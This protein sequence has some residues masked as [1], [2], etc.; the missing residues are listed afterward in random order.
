MPRLSAA[1]AALPLRRRLGSSA[2][3]AL[4]VFGL[5][6]AASAQDDAELEALERE[7]AEMQ[8]A[9][10]ESGDAAADAALED[11]EKQ[12]ED[13]ELPEGGAFDE[14]SWTAEDSDDEPGL[15]ESW[16][17]DPTLD[18]RFSLS[19][20][21]SYTGRYHDFDGFDFPFPDN[22]SADDLA[23]AR[24]LERRHRDDQDHDLDQHLAFTWE[25]FLE[26][27]EESWWSS[28]D[29]DASM[30]YFRDL[31]GSSSGEATLGTFDTFSDNDEFQ[32]LTLSAKTQ[33]FERHLELELGRQYR[34][35]AE[36][37]HFDGAAATFRGL[38]LLDRRA[39]ISAFGGARVR[40]YRRSST[41]RVGIG[42]A[43][44]RWWPLDGLEM[45][46][47]DVWFL[48][49]TLEGR[50]RYRFDGI[51]S[52]ALTYRQIDEDPE[53][54]RLDAALDW[55]EP[56]L[57][58]WFEYHGKLGR[59][60]KDFDFDFTR[61]R[62]RDPSGLEYLRI[63]DLAP[64]D[65]VTLELRKSFLEELGIFAGGTWHRL[66]ERDLQDEYNTDWHEV[67]AGLD[68]LQAPW[69]SLTGRVTFRYLRTEQRR[70]LL[71]LPPG[72]VVSNDAPDFL[73]QDITG[74]GEPDFLG[75]D[76]TLDQRLTHSLSVG[77]VLL[78]RG[79][80]YESNYSM[81]DD[82]NASS[83]SLYTRWRA[84]ERCDWYLSYSWDQDFQLIYPDL[85]ALHT[86]RLQ[87]SW[88]F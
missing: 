76:L 71:R 60:A 19:Y 45:R 51:G 83:A 1:C 40:L 7:Y 25:R 36:W 84:T 30:R 34:Q 17:A 6:G 54:V 87:F 26:P 10:E 49:N 39:E 13:L 37:I 75:V 77:A 11:L 14:T 72:V 65:E 79:Y 33:L 47:S 2:A 42:G 56:G 74:D 63:G 62:R 29:L 82:L 38:T 86:L 15:L 66:R 12:Y 3:H 44:V 8:V 68:F 31:D 43:S 28:V 64:F 80:D 9:G 88:R 61:S 24:E 27:D 67:W 18:G 55:Q 73:P 46:L 53:S 22:L 20:R 35:E 59:D 70:R 78:F 85:E 16:L 57:S 69:E 41:Q 32:L 52:I 48:D 4:L 21:A 58:L 23:W 5:A 81:L 50:A